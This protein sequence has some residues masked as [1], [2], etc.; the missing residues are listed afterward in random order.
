MDLTLTPELTAFRDEVRTFL[1]AHRD[2]HKEGVP[3]DAKAWQKTLFQWRFIEPQKKGQFDWDEA[4]RIVK[5]SKANG[6]K[7]L[8]RLDQQPAWAR[9]DHTA[10]NAPPDNMQDYA[11]FITAFVTRYSAILYALP[12]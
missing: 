3:K 2:E 6:I 12:S 4:D 10:K 11:D 1:E 5:A 7:I 8:A 9:A